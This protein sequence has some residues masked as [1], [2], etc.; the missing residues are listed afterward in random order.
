M[1]TPSQSASSRPPANA[2]QGR[3]KRVFVAGA[4]G[5]IGRYVARELL[6]RGYEVVCLVRKH[7][8]VGANTGP[9][10]V[11]RQLEGC[12]LR[13]GDVT[14]KQSLV[15][16]GFC[17]ERF[18]AIVCCL[19]SRSGGIKDSWRI[20][21]QASKQLLDA[22][23]AAGAVHFL[24]LSA[25]CVQKPR[26][27]FQRA[28]LRMERELI[29]SGVTYSIVRPTAFFKSV[30]GQ[31][32]SV[33]S[34]RPYMMFGDSDA[35]CKPISEADLAEFMANCLEDPDLQNSILPVGGPGEALTARERGELLFELARQKPKFRKIPVAIFSAIIPLLDGL[36]L[37]LPRFADKAEFARIGRYYATESMLVLDAESGLYDAEATPSYGRQTLREFYER[38]LEQGMTGQELGDHSLFNST[39]S[40]KNS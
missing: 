3:R 16:D 13:F 28:K 15:E 10:Q 29:A 6:S 5:Y 39:A 4:T 17:G 40:A 20:D 35:A 11:Q 26:L 21:Y 14:D 31:V 1:T 34:G 25:I 18:D 2:G 27:E 9:E 38:V 30:A 37:L 23:L 32:Q 22:G 33:K 24:L 12:K 36:A 7:S 8:G 19:A